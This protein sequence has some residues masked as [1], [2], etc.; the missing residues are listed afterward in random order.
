MKSPS[1]T[2]IYAPALIRDVS[3]TPPGITTGLLRRGMDRPS[4]DKISEFVERGRLESLDDD[5]DSSYNSDWGHTP[6]QSRSKS[7]SCE[8]SHSCHH[9]RG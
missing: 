2:T 3:G 1:D 6:E 7:R 9:S 8:R 4:I 5:D